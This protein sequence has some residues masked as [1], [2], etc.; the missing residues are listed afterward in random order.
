M[1]A[2]AKPQ[3]SSRVAESR[4]VRVAVV[5]ASSQI[6]QALLPHLKTAGYVAYRIGPTQQHGDDTTLH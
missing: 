5:G 6:G 2:A 3:R 4:A 1:N